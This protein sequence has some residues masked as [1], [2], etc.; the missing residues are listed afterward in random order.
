M[1]EPAGTVVGV[2]LPFQP[3]PRLLAPLEEAAV[4]RRIGW[5]D[6]PEVREAKSDGAR[7]AQWLRAHE[8]PLTDEQ[9]EEL[10]QAEVLFALDLPLDV[11][12]L[13]PH[14]RWV[15]GLGAGVGQ[16][17][18]VLRGGVSNGDSTDGPLG[19][20]RPTGQPIRLCSAAGLSGDKVA[21]F[22]M[23]RLLGVWADLRK[24]DEL[25]RGRCWA[26]DEV[27][28]ETM[29]GR[30]V[31]VVGTGGIGQAVARRATAFD[32]TVVGVRR[33]PELG[34]PAGFQRV[35]GA[36]RLHEVLAEADAVVIAAPAT[37]QTRHLIGRDELAA[38]RLGAVLCNVARGSL[39]D[40]GA[41][42]DALRSGHLGAAVLDVTEH[43]PL[44][45]RSPLWTAPRAYLSPH[46]AN[47]WRPEY[48]AR[49]VDLL[50][51]NLARERAGKPL[52]NE[53]DLG[54]GY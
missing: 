15:Q 41:V 50:V 39:V 12:D 38:M 10:E 23:A 35:V 51:E 27:R 46:V 37:G 18:A 36:D 25:Q 31:A 30:T 4:V 5:A 33:R 20:N 43:E 22:V 28:A 14:L 24:L 26:P 21:E 32:L 19:R 44:S 6:S 52:R 29:A 16:L 8:R 3:D 53:V 7:S 17:V 54:A 45:R 49:V 13:A 47:A 34:A 2:L 48:M 9:R 42:V 11:V 40:E 1:A